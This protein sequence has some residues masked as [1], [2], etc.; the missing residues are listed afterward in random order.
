VSLSRFSRRSLLGRPGRTILTVLS[1]VIGVAA[2]VSVTILVATTREAYKMMF[3]TV[4]GRAN[5]EVAALSGASF[6]ESLVEKVAAVEGVEAAVPIVEKLSSMTIGETRV[7]LQILGIDP[8]RDKLVRD[9]DVVDGRMVESGDEVVLESDFARQMQIRV[10]DTVKMLTP[11]RLRG[12]SAGSKPMEVVGLVKPKGAAALQ[13]TGMVFMPLARAQLRFTGRG[14]IDSIQIVTKDGADEAQVQAAIQKLLPAG[15]EARP[16][17]GAAASLRQTLLSTNQGLVVTTAFSLLL[18]AFI[19]LNTFLMNVG[20]RRR[21]LAIMRAIGATRLQVELMLVGE[22]LLLGM[23]GTVLGIGL[24]LLTAYG[25]NRSLSRVLDVTLPALQLSWTPFV[26][27]VVFGFGISVLGALVPAIRAG[28]VSPL[29]GMSRVLSQDFTRPPWYW[30]AA[31]A[32]V[33][34]V[35]GAL[36]AAGILGFVPIDITTYAGLAFHLGVVLLFPLVLAPMSH[37]IATFLA[38]INQAERAL[39][40]KQILRHRGRTGLTV[41]VLFIAGSAGL[42]MSHSILDNVQDIQDWRATAIIGDYYVRAMI[43]DMATGQSADLPEELE[44]EIRAVPGIAYLD[45]V[46]LNKAEVGQESAIIIAREFNE[47]GKLP[48]DLTEGDPREVRQ[49]LYA[50]EVVVST[51]LAQKQKLKTGDHVTLG[52][53]EGEKRFRI[54]GIINEYIAGGLVVYMEWQTAVRELG[55]TGVDGFVVRAAPGKI[56]DLEA[57]LEALARKHGVIVHSQADINANIHRIIRGIDGMLWGLVFLGFVV[58][59]FGVVNTLSMNVLEQTRELGLLRIVAMTRKQVRRTIVVQAMIIGAVGLIP[60]VLVGYGIAYVMNLAM[61]PSFGRD[62]EFH[63]RPGLMLLT[64]CG[65]LAIT[66]LAAW[67]PARRA[68]GIDVATALH[69][70]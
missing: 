33:A 46:K 65:A 53:V 47:P 36:I 59:A 51:I 66:I 22:A 62:I 63:H 14:K 60:G 10:G 50:G 70:E 19:I 17:S 68:A 43:P 64:F 24:G 13:Q 54:C 28:R 31:G 25:L 37:A 6:D 39:A 42:G 55:M 29:E 48:L 3:A 52:T 35:G 56:R 32:I 20:E 44:P 9:L 26:W 67:I 11:R 27:A 8:Q 4:K 45:R 5:L 38:Y 12:E 49:R 61:E 34:L 2:V 23:I 7:R 16:P 69:Y 40:L 41:G 58:A 21:H 57:P 18:A 30:Q 15:L 1:I